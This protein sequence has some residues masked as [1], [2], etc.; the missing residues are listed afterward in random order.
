MS[1]INILLKICTTLAVVR[2]VGAYTREDESR[3]L[4]DLIVRQDKR[5]K[6]HGSGN[7]TFQ[8]IMT[9]GMIQI[10]EV[11]EK[12][13]IFDAYYFM[14]QMWADNQL[15]W[16][17]TEYNG[18]QV[19]N[20]PDDTI[21]MPSIGLDNDVDLVRSK[22]S[23][24]AT[25]T[26]VNSLGYVGRTLL[27]NYRSSCDM[28]LKNFPFDKQNCTL[29]FS[30]WKHFGSELNLTYNDYLP[31]G[32]YTE[33]S[34]FR[35]INMSM[36]RTEDRECCA[37]PIIKLH[38]NIL[39]E[40]RPQFYLLNMILP[41]TLITLIAMFAFCIPPES[42]EKIGLGVTVLL[43]LSV[44]LLIVSEQ[45][46]PT[47]EFPLIGTYYFGVILIVTFS[48]GVSVMTLSLNHSAS[49]RTKEVPRIL[50]SLLYS[51]LPML[52]CMA[53]FGNDPIDHS[54]PNQF[55]EARSNKLNKVGH[56][57][58]EKKP[59]DIGV[60][61]KKDSNG[62]KGFGSDPMSEILKFI[63][64]IEEKQKEEQKKED[65]AE[66]W[67]YLGRLIDRILLV[68]FLCLNIIFTLW[69]LLTAAHC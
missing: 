41:C 16:N 46:P 68:L 51:R 23:L 62:L 3:L 31:A 8:V 7:E 12:N 64:G 67:K 21:W 25:M 34:E 17:V 4:D 63:R 60:E 6:P 19:M 48:T 9:A 13:Q 61:S 27:V 14:M 29:T 58:N 10:L 50:Q 30:S 52:L 44:F 20:V 47:T 22:N 55:D 59:A 11:D 42:G 43:S 2:M 38:L 18:I 1:Q 39:F 5:I 35:L 24:S 36:S 26:Q 33:S 15:A 66:Q 56:G 57:D 53:P 65:I 45:M 54:S 40:R 32:I 28:S 49:Y 37:A 69:I